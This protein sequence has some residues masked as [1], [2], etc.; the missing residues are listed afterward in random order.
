V[1]RL[2][3]DANETEDVTAARLQPPEHGSYAG[4]RLAGVVLAAVTFPLTVWMLV[5][6]VVPILGWPIAAWILLLALGLHVAGVL[7][8]WSPRPSF[9]AG[10]ALML[11]LA[12]TSVPG[13]SSAALVPSSA[14]FVLLVWQLASTQPRAIALAGLVISVLG[15]G[16]IT[17]VDTVT[18]DTR[19]LLVIA[20]EAVALSALVIAGWA[21]GRDARRRRFADAADAERRVRDAVAAERV[22]IGR[23]LHDVVSHALT[24]MIAQAEA[25][26][27]LS[28]TPASTAAIERVAETGR[29]AM[30]GLRGMLRLVGDAGSP[31]GLAPTPDLRGISALVE[32]ATTPA[33]RIAF[34]QDGAIGGLRP[35]AN[36]ALLRATQ[37]ALTNVVRHVRPPVNVEVALV[38]DDD[39]VVL[40]VADDGGMGSRDADTGGTGLV[41]LAERVAQAGGTLEIDR[42]RGWTVR[43]TMPVEDAP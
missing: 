29:S 7:S 17:A 4:V 15:A 6:F 16:V 38:W 24:V 41:G 43:V 10:A 3:A 32:G 35:D 5:Q 33:H 37:E 31:A 14:T 12:L 34:R 42:G 26:R 8:F 36:L 21:W 25:A 18:N 13:M 39:A 19:E 20:F 22:R 9:V 40:R 30:D 28:D 27:V 23:D 11:A 2:A 1:R